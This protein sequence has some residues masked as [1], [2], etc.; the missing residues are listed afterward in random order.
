MLSRHPALQGSTSTQYDCILYESHLAPEKFVRHRVTSIISSTLVFPS[1]DVGSR[2][3]RIVGYK[4][5]PY[6]F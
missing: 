5:K 1:L 6:N 4:H 2:G 3:T